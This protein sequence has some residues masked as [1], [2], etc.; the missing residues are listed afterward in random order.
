MPHTTVVA[1]FHAS[2]RQYDEPTYGRAHDR[3]ERTER[4]GAR[5][6][7]RRPGDA[8]LRDAQE[9]VALVVPQ[10]QRAGDRKQRLGRRADCRPILE[11]GVPR[12][13]DSG[14]RRNLLAAQAGDA[15]IRSARQPDVGRLHARAP[16]A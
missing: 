8:I 11:H 13:T 4:E 7:A 14:E 6:V 3:V 2:T 10:P 1:R 9:I 16:V 5:D 15:P 12:D